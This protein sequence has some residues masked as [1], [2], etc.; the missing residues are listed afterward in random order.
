MTKEVTVQD[1][2]LLKVL[3]KSLKRRKEKGI[4]PVIPQIRDFRKFRDRPLTSIFIMPTQGGKLLEDTLVSV[5]SQTYK[6]TEIFVIDNGKSS[7]LTSLL[8]TKFPNIGIIVSENNSI[9][10]NLNKGIA[11]SNGEII[12]FINEG[13]KWHPDK[14]EKHWQALRDDA[15]CMWVTCERKTKNTKEN[16]DLSTIVIRKHVLTDIKGFATTKDGDYFNDLIVKLRKG[17][18]QQVHLK[19]I[20][21][22]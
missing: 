8:N 21:V 1:L 7:E 13:D 14:L 12:A 11:D 9:I 17:N 5:Q 4:I 22:Q 6:N 20:L 16:F 15:Y 19:E 2:N 10:D 18:F 3:H